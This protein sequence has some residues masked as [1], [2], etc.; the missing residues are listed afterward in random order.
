MDE[1]ENEFYGVEG[2]T[3][4]GLDENLE[5]LSEAS[6]GGGLMSFLLG[7]FANAML[8]RI[9]DNRQF[10]SMTRD[11]SMNS[12][13]QP[14]S[15]SSKKK[16]FLKTAWR[17]EEEIKSSE[18]EGK[19]VRLYCLLQTV[20]HLCESEWKEVTESDSDNLVFINKNLLSL[21]HY[22]QDLKP[23]SRYWPKVSDQVKEA[24]KS[25]I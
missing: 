19:W 15:L 2:E 24:L 9:S 1:F 20:R 18:K 11:D 25:V 6:S 17:L 14:S 10:N 21:L 4:S 3:S 8:P 7:G 22:V 5:L 12:D 23:E 13:V 16:E